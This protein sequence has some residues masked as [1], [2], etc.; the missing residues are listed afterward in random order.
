MKTQKSELYLGL[1]F[2]YRQNQSTNTVSYSPKNDSTKNY[3]DTFGTKRN[4]KGLNLTIGN[5]FTLGSNFIIEPYFGIG[6]QIKKIKNSNIQYSQ[7]KDI[8]NGTGLVPFF[9]KL[10][11]EEGAGTDIDLSFG[12]RIGYKL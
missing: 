4:V 6:F 12:F 9:Q 7:E 10:N 3:N 2:F 8:R 5:Q 11:L 1:Q